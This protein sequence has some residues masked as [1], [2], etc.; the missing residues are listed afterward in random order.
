MWQLQPG[1]KIRLD[2]SSSDFPQ[3]SVHSNYA[4][5][6]SAQDKTRVAHQTLFLDD[7]SR[8]E[9]PLLK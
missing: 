7:K 8:I 3:Y 1:S 9:I 5:V 6:W 4:G 2:I